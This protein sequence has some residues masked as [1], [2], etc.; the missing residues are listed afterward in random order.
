MSGVPCPKCGNSMTLAGRSRSGKVKWICRIKG[1][2]YCYSTTAP[3][4]PARRT[5]GTRFDSPPGDKV[6]QR[7]LKPGTQVYVIT[8]AQN[9]TP[10]DQDFWACLNQVAKCREAE[11]LAI[12]IRYKNP[13]SRWTESQA[14]EEVWAPELGPYLWNTRRELNRNLV[15]LGDIKVQATASEPLNGFD[16]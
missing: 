3:K 14:N 7:R 16:S 8:A 11:L 5:D 4:S 10:V 6:F 12:P 2:K 9:A 15:L 13:T 1:K